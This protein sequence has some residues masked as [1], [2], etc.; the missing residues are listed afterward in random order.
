[1]ATCQNA[2]SLVNN[3]VTNYLLLVPAKKGLYF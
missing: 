3:F 1:M 2:A